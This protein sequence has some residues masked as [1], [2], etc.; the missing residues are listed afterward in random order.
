MKKE[1]IWVVIIG[2]SIGGIVE[3]TL[4]FWAGWNEEPIVWAKVARESMHNILI[5]Y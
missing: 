2:I 3:A 4:P 5:A 1:F